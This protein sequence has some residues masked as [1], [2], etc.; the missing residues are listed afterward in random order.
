MSAG[1]IH[2]VIINPQNSYW[3]CSFI[4]LNIIANVAIML[5]I[6]NASTA[7]ADAASA[8]GV[9]RFSLSLMSC[10]QGT[11]CTCTRTLRTRELT[12]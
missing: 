12:G 3:I 6:H 5:Q 9:S 10:C 11:G 8:E 7:D 1:I 4:P 2:A